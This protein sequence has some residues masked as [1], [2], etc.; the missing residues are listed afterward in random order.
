MLGQMAGFSTE[1]GEPIK[2]MDK[3]SLLG[4]MEENTLEYII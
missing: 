4:P 2:C 1:N 3:A